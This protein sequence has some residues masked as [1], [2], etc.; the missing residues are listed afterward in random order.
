MSMIFFGIILILVIC[1]FV[2]KISLKAGIY[3]DNYVI[4]KP[5]GE[6]SKK[7]PFLYLK[8]DINKITFANNNHFQK[9][10]IQ[11][12]FDEISSVKLIQND[13]SVCLNNNIVYNFKIPKINLKMLERMLSQLQEYKNSLVK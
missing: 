10:I 7:Y 12:G 5:I 11:K 9:I 6:L 1:L 13:F 4:A 3:G 2:A 8:L